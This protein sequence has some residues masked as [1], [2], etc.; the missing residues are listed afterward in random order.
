MTSERSHLDRIRERFTDSAKPFAQFVLATRAGEAARLADMATAN[1][2]SVGESKAESKAIDVAC[3]PGTFARAFAGRFARV[4]GVDFTPEML[5]QGRQ[6]TTR[7]GLANMTF[8]R[9]DAYA[10]PFGDETF[11]VAVCSY[12]LH[13]LLYPERVLREM[14]RVVG[15]RGRVAIADLVLA[16]GADVDAHNQ[17]ER[18]R[19]PSHASTLT[20]T[21]IHRSL[22]N[23]GL[24]VF[25]AERH[26]RR[27]D[28]DEWM[29]T[30]GQGPGTQSYKATRGL[31]EKCLMNDDAGFRPGFD[32]KT[33]TL[34]FGQTV[35][36]VTAEKE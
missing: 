5:H 24:R 33:G 17:I 16:E 31:V 3:G 11:D 18:A 19:D 9:T 4:V 6:M 28:F 1:A 14:A 13:H 7:E 10:L 35:L 25:A 23:E 32:A 36:F 30:A 29:H 15:R 34:E 21:D 12:A 2:P 8:L 27:R 20:E 26:E 22:K